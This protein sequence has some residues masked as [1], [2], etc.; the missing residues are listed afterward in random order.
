MT[1]S[2]IGTSSRTYSTL[3]AWAN[4]C[5]AN[6]TAGGTNEIWKG[7]CYNDSEFLIS[8]GDYLLQVPAV[9]SDATHYLHLTTASGQSFK[10]NA[11]DATL[12]LSYDQSKGVGFRTTSHYSHAI[13]T[14]NTGTYMT[15]EGIQLQTT[16]GYDTL[17]GRLIVKDCIIEWDKNVAL[18][19]ANGPQGDF[20]NCVIVSR[21]SS[22]S[23]TVIR[24]PGRAFNCTVVRPSDL[25]A[26]GVAFD[27]Y[28]S[29]PLV[30]NCAIFGFTTM[31]GSTLASYPAGTDYNASSVAT[32]SMPGSNNQGSLTYSSQF[33][34]VN[35]ATRDWRPKSG[36]A[37]NTNGTRD[38]TNTND[39]D[40]IGAARSTTTPS[41]GAREFAA[42]GGA[43]KSHLVGGSLTNNILLS[44]LKG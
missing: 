19:D 6:I 40:I 11:G 42:G 27:N 44:G 4:A 29:Y 14:T 35:N 39:L 24:G 3:Q 2:S 22:F 33:E 15:V 10:D 20:I 34:N 36:G 23:G 5:P 1:T 38:Q 21:V 32:G 31:F 25:T 41:I 16:S 13:H 12:P 9:T 17:A 18:W 7:E 8:T 30:K 28:F 37:L 26:G 43:T